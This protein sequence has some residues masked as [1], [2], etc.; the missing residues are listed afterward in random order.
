MS[1]LNTLATPEQASST[2][3]RQD[4]I[5]LE[6]E[7]SLRLF[8]SLLIQ[9]ASHSCSLPQ[10]VRTTACTLYQRF[11][12][13]SSFRSFSAPDIALSSLFLASKLEESPLRIRDLINTFDYI[14]DYIAWIRE[15]ETAGGSSRKGW[16]YETMGYHDPKYYEYR[17]EAAA[18]EMQI[19]K[20]LGFHV[21]VQP[22]HPILANYLQVLSLV[23][24]PTIP[25][26]AWSLLNDSLLTPLPALHPPTLLAATAIYL[27]SRMADPPVPLPLNPRPWWEL[28]DVE[29]EGEMEEVGRTIL[30]VRKRG[31][32][33]GDV[34][35]WMA[36]LPVG[37]KGVR[38]WLE[39]R[40]NES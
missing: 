33:E 38:E 10:A 39:M 3:S 30:E 6:M 25:Q 4:G 11:F 29:S 26:D 17:D 15:E 40:G 2:P 13:V 18:G 9:Q 8:G 16:K 19:L 24:H 20:R 14:L 23:S 32:A 28:F 27:A 35:T 1:L 12:Y 5:P 7:T 31:E 34:W 37:K 22:S 36:S 21:S